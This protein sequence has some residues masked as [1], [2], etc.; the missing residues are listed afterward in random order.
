MVNIR[1]AID[2]YLEIVGDD[3]LNG[4]GLEAIEL[5]V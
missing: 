5:V 3:I 1:E 4:D 2:F